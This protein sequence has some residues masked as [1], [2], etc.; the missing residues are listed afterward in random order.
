MN[1]T[2]EIHTY[3]NTHYRFNGNEYGKNRL[4]LAIINDYIQNH[5]G[6]TLENLQTTFP[7]RLQGALG[8][9]DTFE[10]ANEIYTRTNHKRHFLIRHV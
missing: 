6:C 5:D 2:D 7:K 8:V 4:V 1:G 10:N 3:D 9:V